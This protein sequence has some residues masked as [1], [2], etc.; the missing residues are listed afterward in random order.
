MEKKLKLAD[1]CLHVPVFSCV[2]VFICMTC[3]S[4]ILMHSLISHQRI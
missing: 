1:M 2:V 4:D 3:I